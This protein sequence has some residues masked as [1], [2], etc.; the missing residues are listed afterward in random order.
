MAD[1]VFD[2]LL[3]KGTQGGRSAESIT[4]HTGRVVE[5]VWELRTARLGDLGMGEGFWRALLKAAALHDLGKA[6]SGFQAALAGGAPWRRRHEVASLAFLSSA[7]EEGS[8]EWQQLAAWVLSHHRSLTDLVEQYGAGEDDPAAGLEELAAELPF[9]AAQD[10]LPLLTRLG[11]TGDEASAGSEAGGP[12]AVSADA[13]AANIRTALSALET[14]GADLRAERPFGPRRTSALLGR[15]LLM[16]A[17][18]LA[19]AHAPTLQGLAAVTPEELARRAGVEGWRPHQLAAKGGPDRALLVAPTGSGKTEAALLWA[20]AARQEGDL[21]AGRPRG[22]LAYLLPYQA[23]LNAMAPRLERLAGR[24]VG[25]LHGHSVDALYRAFR[26]EVS[27]GEA[28]RLARRSEDLARLYAPPVVLTTPYHLLRAALRL[29]GHA[30]TWAV[31]RHAAIVMDEVHVYEPERLGLLVAVLEALA[32]HWGARLLVMSATIPEWLEAFL[33]RRLGLCR[34]GASGEESEAH[35]RHR[36]RLVGPGEAGRSTEAA[37]ACPVRLAIEA[38]KAG[39]SVLLCVNSVRRAIAAWEAVTESWPKEK[40]ILLHSRLTARDRLERETELLRRMDAGERGLVAVATQVVEVSLDVDFEVGITEIAPPD[41][42]AQR[43]GRV[44]RRGRRGTVDAFVVGDDDTLSRARRVYRGLPEGV[45]ERTLEW[46]RANEGREMSEGALR[47]WMNH[48]YEPVAA[49]WTAR[50]ERQAQR[51]RE[52]TLRLLTGMD[53]GDSVDAFERLFGGT[54]AVPE[55]LTDEFAD[56]VERSVLEA[57]QFLVPVQDWA[58][59]R[60][61]RVS[62]GARERS[63]PVRVVAAAYDRERGLLL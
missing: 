58:F 20:L 22:T 21:P 35:A 3:A 53:D 6:A 40:T 51:L 5:R 7:A 25:L 38:A 27:A 29:P 32:D 56:A 2:R 52:G 16:L 54:E 14:F 43:L 63:I 11:L 36:L 24:P 47:E 42:I 45:L 26:E 17:D 60:C 37:D 1:L 4:E 55:N 49:V 61:R 34:V 57:M 48:A 46:L 59:P 30:T 15:G 44:N 41:A 9:S 13:S 18:R 12:A 28:E 19:S 23:S 8:E 39:R 62:L 10:V 50:A 33:V 31:L